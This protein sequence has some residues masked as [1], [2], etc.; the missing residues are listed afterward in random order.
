M[1]ICHYFEIHVQKKANM[2]NNT[3]FKS[4]VKLLVELRLE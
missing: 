1:W 2:K 3:I 4:D